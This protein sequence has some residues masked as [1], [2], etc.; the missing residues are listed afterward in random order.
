MMDDTI[1]PPTPPRPAPDP[2]S[3]NVAAR[4]GAFVEVVLCSDFPTQLMLIQVLAWIGLRPLL[5]DGGLSLAYVATLS[6]V[7]AAA[8]IA[9]MLWLLHRRDESVRDAFL[10]ARPIGREVKLGILLVP[11]IVLF[12]LVTLLLI[13]QFAPALHNVAVNPLESL[14]KT[15]RNAWI[16]ATVAIVAG[17]LREELQRAFILRRFEQHLGGARVGLVVFSVAFGA[18]HLLQGWDAAIVTAM[19]GL[20]WGSVFLA[21]RSIVAPLVSHA[22]FNLVEIVRHVAVVEW[23]AG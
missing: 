8:L 19:L 2:P 6:L 5:G 21:R 16:F 14:L 10:G 12:V 20:I 15:P 23:V 22:C 9:L 18:G 1:G 17:G 7:D 11:G 13:Q 3:S 4:V